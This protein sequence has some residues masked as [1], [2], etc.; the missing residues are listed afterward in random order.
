MKFNL[1][2]PSPPPS[3]RAGRS[4]APLHPLA[5]A[6]LLEK[7][8]HLFWLLCRTAKI[9][10]LQT[11][12]HSSTTESRSP[13][14]ETITTNP[15]RCLL[16]VTTDWA[17]KMPGLLDS[18]YSTWFSRRSLSLRSPRFCFVL[19]TL[20]LSALSSSYDLRDYS[21][22]TCHAVALRNGYANTRLLMQSLESSTRQLSDS[23]GSSNR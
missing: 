8:T 3:P 18:I 13:R 20:T 17:E 16:R 1:T 9:K 2:V 15:W 4:N 7:G 12:R 11:S 6:A 19:N 5:A 10:M 23:K 14:T 21:L 22:N